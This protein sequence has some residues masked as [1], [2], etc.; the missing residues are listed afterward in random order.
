MWKRESWLSAQVVLAALNLEGKLVKLNK[1]VFR[2]HYLVQ[3]NHN[4]W[5]AYILLLL[6]TTSTTPTLST[7]GSLALVLLPK[8][9]QPLQQINQWVRHIWRP[10]LFLHQLDV[11]SASPPFSPSPLWH[12]VRRL[13]PLTHNASRGR[14]SLDQ[15]CASC[16]KQTYGLMMR[17]WDD[18]FTV[19]AGQ[20][21]W[22]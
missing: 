6:L 11:L 4:P 9:P 20:P 7:A 14:R 13:L 5:L 19:W 2:S 8:V 16:V 15:P 12:F 22:D 17:R 1:F 10:Q 21:R 18:L 3:Y